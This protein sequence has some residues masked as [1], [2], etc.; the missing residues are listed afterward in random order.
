MP[1]MNW[2]ILFQAFGFK[3]LRCIECGSIYLKYN[4]KTTRIMG[5]SCL[6]HSDK[7]TNQL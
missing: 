1:Y 6:R 5:E 2:Q 3:F 7:H 4:H